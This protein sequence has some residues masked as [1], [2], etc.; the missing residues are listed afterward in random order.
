[1]RGWAARRGVGGGPGCPP[2]AWGGP[3]GGKGELPGQ[4]GGLRRGGRGRRQPPA[5]PHQGR[6][7]HD[8]GRER[9]ADVE[10]AHRQR[11][12]DRIKVLGRGVRQFGDGRRL[13]DR[14]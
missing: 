9:V 7:A 4:R 13:G 5:A 1:G 2:P 8:R 6:R 10:V 11:A 12:G 3:Q 14:R